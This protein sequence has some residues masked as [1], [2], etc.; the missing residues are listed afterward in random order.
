MVVP[1]LTA[2]PTEVRRKS[3]IDREMEVADLL[4]ER[5]RHALTAAELDG[6]RDGAAPSDP[7]LVADQSAAQDAAAGRSTRWLT[8]SPITTTLSSPNCRAFMP[9]SKRSWRARASRSRDGLPSFLRMGSWIGGDRDGNPFVDE[10]VLRGALR[11]RAAA[12][13]AIISTNCTCSAASCRSTPAWSGVS[14]ALE[15]LAARSPDRSANRQNEPYRRAITG[16]YARLAATA[17][18]FD[19]L[20]AP[21]HA[22]GDA[23]PYGDSGELLADLGDHRRL[24]GRQRVG[25]P[26]ARAGSRICAALS[27]SSAFTWRRSICGRIPMCT[28]AASAKCSLWRSRASTMPVSAR[29]SASGC[30]WRSSTTARPLASA[31]LPYSAETASEL[32][33]VRAAAEAHRRYGPASV[34][35]YVISKATSVSDIL[36]TAVLLKEAGLLRPRDGVLDVDIVPLF[37]T[38]EDLRHC[39]EVMDELLGLPEYARLLD[40]RGPHAGG[41]ARLFRQQQGW[42]FSDLGLGVVQGRDGAGRSV[43]PP[44]GRAAP[45]SRPRRLGRPRRRPELSG[46]PRPARR[47]PFRARSALPSRA[48]SSPANI[49]TPS[50][51]GAISKPSPPRR[52]KPPCCNRKRA[53]PRPE[54]LAAME[55][56]SAEAYRAYREPRLRN[57]RVRPLFPRID[58]DR[59]DRQ[60]EYRQPPVVAQSLGDDRGSARDPLG[61]QLGAMP[62]DAAGL[63][64]VRQC[65]RGLARVAAERRHGACCRRCTA[66]GRSFR[67]CCR[68]WTWCW[69]RAISRSPRAMP[70]WSPTR[71]C[72]IASS[73]GLRAEWQS[74]VDALL[75]IIG[76]NSL[77]ESNPLLARS[78]R[79]RFPYLDPLNHMQIELLKR[80]RGGDADDDVVTGI[81]LTINGIAAGLRNSG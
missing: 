62:A 24:A 8:A 67:C 5:D 66:N 76:Q 79:N 45:V 63:V 53:A 30:C 42:R 23:A 49:R 34:P 57:R 7:D 48:R 78:I 47:A 33:I 10:A 43:P 16:I 80:Y 55:F 36:E 65:G 35:H 29:P 70:I 19:H 74:V 17:R 39:G 44:R 4:A 38:I 27:M 37:E 56:L 77:L 13:C 14:E 60:S 59:R 75:A 51:A 46:D 31:F 61:V 68:T 2:H 9:I 20:D 71:R 50:S 41:H 52:S 40:S 81:H 15:A 32:A 72:A 3:T 28:S 11:R 6:Q 12:H 58:G 1:V 69:P 26:G 21:Q 73:P 54:Y 22:V 64:R 18:A 25:D